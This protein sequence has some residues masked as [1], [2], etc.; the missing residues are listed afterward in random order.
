[1]TSSIISY[2]R[3]RLNKEPPSGIHGHNVQFNFSTDTFSTSDG[4][5]IVWGH[6]AEEAHTQRTRMVTSVLHDSGVIATGHCEEGE[7]TTTNPNKTRY[8]MNRPVYQIQDLL[9]VL[10]HHII[11]RPADKTVMLRSNIVGYKDL[12]PLEQ[13]TLFRAPPMSLLFHLDDLLVRGPDSKYQRPT[14]WPT[15][16]QIL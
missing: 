2:G 4:F 15:V 3:Q 6:W 14:P 10:A 11:S 5:M 7:L 12:E 16:S 8:D 9:Q 13:L 1:M